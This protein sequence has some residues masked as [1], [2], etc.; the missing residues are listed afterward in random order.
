MKVPGAR[1]TEVS[2]NL[3]AQLTRAPTMDVRREGSGET[4]RDIY[5]VTN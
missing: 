2:R 3:L 4:K 1:F 5:D